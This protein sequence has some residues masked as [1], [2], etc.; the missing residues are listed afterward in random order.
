MQVNIIAASL[1]VAGLLISAYLL[2]AQYTNS[3]VICPRTK[4][5]DCNKILRS[6]YRNIFGIP[7][8]LLGI[9]FFLVELFLLVFGPVVLLLPLNIV[10]FLYALSRV[11][12]Q[13]T[14]KKVCLYCSAIALIVLALL[15]IT[16]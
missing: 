7:T 4:L 2:W 3:D 10:G 11:Y 12:V 6:R 13:I 5:I 9:L 8:A 1:S 14:M 16:A 15:L